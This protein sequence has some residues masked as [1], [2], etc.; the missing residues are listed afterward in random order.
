MALLIPYEFKLQNRLMASSPAMSSGVPEDPLARARAMIAAAREGAP[1]GIDPRMAAILDR[2]LQRADEQE[3]ELQRAQKGTIWEALMRAG[4][5]MASNQSPF[6]APALAAGANAALSAVQQRRAEA[7]RARMGLADMRDDVE[8]E[9]IKQEGAGMRAADEGLERV[10]RIGN[11]LGEADLRAAQAMKARAEA[12]PDPQMRA[13]ELRKAEMQIR[14]IESKIAENRAQAVRALREGRGGGAST[15]GAG[16]L[17]GAGASLTEAEK[18]ARG[19]DPELPWIYDAKGIPRLP[20]GFKAPAGQ[21]GSVPPENVLK[22][23]GRARTLLP[24]AS[25]GGISGILTRGAE[26]FGA[27]TDR[28]KADAALRV[29]AGQLTASVPRFEGPQALPEVKLYQA[30]AADVANSDLPTETRLAALSEME[31]MI[32]RNMEFKSQRRASQGGGAVVRFDA[33]GRRIP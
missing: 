6:F 4:T 2:R 29:V 1:Q 9:R 5:A 33:Q 11:Q 17:G 16:A 19:L 32:R 23:I 28:S 7:A 14:E 24:E 27:S 31:K 30:M 26:M 22:T 10:L 15:G 18:N 21:R 12:I 20:V 25:G 13:L 3:R 8:M